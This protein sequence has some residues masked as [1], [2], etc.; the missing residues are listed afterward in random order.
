MFEF[1]FGAG[2]TFD[3]AYTSML[4]RA[5]CTYNNIADE[6]DLDWI[7]LHK[8]WRLNERH[9]GELQ[10]WNK[11]ETAKKY[12]E[13]QVL[14]WRRSYDNPPPFVA[15]NDERHPRFE[16]K[17][18]SL[19]AA[20]LPKG[21]SLKM[22]IQR[23]IPYW[24]DTICPAVMDNKKVIVVAHEN[25][26]RGIVGTLSGMSNEE[27]LNYN[28]PY[29]TPFVY[30]FDRHLNPLRYYYLLGEDL[31]EEDVLLKEKFVAS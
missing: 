21:E 11:K 19:P 23:V 31:T 2:F 28:I 1:N 26:L 14:N 15:W 9:Y 12:G 25:V 24:Q 3:I 16:E 6:L 4:K 20:V 30:E 17:Y 22:A 13:E 5:I 29:A 27:L 10:G 7:P 18:S 8:H